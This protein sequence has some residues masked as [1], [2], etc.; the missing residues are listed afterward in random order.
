MMAV[1]ARSAAMNANLITHIGGYPRIGRK[2]ELKQALEAFWAGRSD[3]I[4][5]DEVARGLRRRHWQ[6][7]AEAG[8]DLVTVNDFSLYD[9]MLDLAC[10]FGA[11]PERFGDASSPVTL[12]RYFRMARGRARKDLRPDVAALEL[13]KWFDTNYHYLVPELSQDQALHFSWDKPVRELREALDSGHRAKVVLIGPVTFL[14]LSKG[15]GG[16]PLDLLEKL[17]PAYRDLLAALATGGAE[18]VEIAEPILAS[19]KDERILSA[20]EQTWLDDG[21]LRT[22]PG[23]KFLLSVANGPIGV[24]ALERLAAL[25]FDGLHVDAVRGASDLTWLLRHWPVE[26][27]LSLGVIDGRSIWRANPESWRAI[28]ETFRDRRP[29]STLWLGSSCSLQHVPHD[30]KDETAM[31]PGL[32][33]WLAFAKEKLAELGTI[34]SGEVPFEA[35]AV[36]GAAL[37]SRQLHPS[38]RIPEVRE[39]VS[40][41]EAAS[42]RR[43]TP[44]VG[45]TALQRKLLDLP[46]FPTTSIGS[47]P[48]TAEIRALRARHRKGIEDEASYQSGLDA[49]LREVIRHQE[50]LGLDV[51]VHGEFERTDMVEFFGEKL[52]GI[53]VTANGWVQSYGSRCVKPPIIWGDIVRP[54]PMTVD[55]AVRA[56]ALTSRPMKGMLTG[57]ITIL[58]WSFVRD[59]LPRSSVA[60]QLAFALRAEVADLESAGIR[61]IQ[62]DEPGLREGFPLEASA[63]QDYLDWAVRAFRVATSGVRDET[64]IHTHMCYAEFSDVA[65]AIAA[66]D[67]DVITLEASRSKMKA[68]GA[69]TMGGIASEVGPG[70]WDIHSPRV[71]GVEEMVDLLRRAEAVI[72][73]ERLWVNPDCGLKTRGWEETRASLENLVAAARWLREEH[74]RRGTVPAQEIL[75]EN[76]GAL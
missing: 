56:Q 57:P 69:V 41:F 60:M 74:A 48:Q 68:L 58:Q 18:W 34:A 61:I 23:L 46:L 62:V 3:A 35:L 67:V 40:S 2:R 32:R 1:A 7:Q 26:R 59:D 52:E 6:E 33:S 28:V 25:S 64:Q 55:V 11:V 15:S 42:G 17:L 73:A 50:E 43:S 8:L 65:E 9:P 75:R 21:E 29:A 47:F 16:D 22:V 30:L 45:R 20:L 36:A 39:A 19:R 31:D 49:A 38:V 53:S 54:K 13:T 12:D 24:E 37:S 51:L 70:V 66:L 5:L 4:C 63:R 27:V 14:A 72:P 71:P 76:A 10:V 44:V